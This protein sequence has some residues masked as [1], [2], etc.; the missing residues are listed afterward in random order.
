[1]SKI[2]DTPY[3][4]CGV[5]V[6]GESLYLYRF[7]LYLCSISFLYCVFSER[8]RRGQV[9]SLLGQVHP[10]CILL[11]VPANRFAS[12]LR[13]GLYVIAFHIVDPWV[14]GWRCVQSYPLRAYSWDNQA[15]P[16]LALRCSGFSYHG[17]LRR[18]VLPGLTSFSIVGY[19]AW[20]QFMQG[21]CSCCSLCLS[22]THAYFICPRKVGG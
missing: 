21:A 10:R 14:L 13:T 17:P 19:P 16:W 3:A 9:P 4:L 15:S 2:Y 12:Y 7:S 8:R 5:S 22:L 20:W 6:W 11:S 18:G 1:M